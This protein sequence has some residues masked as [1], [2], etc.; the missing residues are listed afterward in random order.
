MLCI[1]PNPRQHIVLVLVGILKFINQNQRITRLHK[2]RKAA[3]LRILQR[4]SQ[5]ADLLRKGG[6]TLLLQYLRQAFFDFGS[7]IK[8]QIAI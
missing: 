3:A 5:S 1:T 7:Q 2:A 6:F 4:L 8:L